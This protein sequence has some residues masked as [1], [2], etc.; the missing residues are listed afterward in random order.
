MIRRN[1]LGNRAGA[2]ATT[3]AATIATA[4]SG[5]ALSAIARAETPTLESLGHE[6]A[7]GAFTRNVFPLLKDKCTKCHDGHGDGHGSDSVDAPKLVMPED[8]SLTYSTIRRYIANWADLAHSKLVIRGTSKDMADGALA[9]EQFVNALQKWWDEGE[10]TAFFEG[11]KV[12]SSRKLPTSGEISLN[13]DLAEV[14]PQMKGAR[15]EIDV[16]KKAGAY[17]LRNP[18][19]EA[20]TPV[21]VHGIHIVMNGAWNTAANGYVNINAVVSENRKILSHDEVPLLEMKPGADELTFAFEKI[22]SSSKTLTDQKQRQRDTNPPRQAQTEREGPRP[23]CG[24]ICWKIRALH[25]DLRSRRVR[26]GESIECRGS[27]Q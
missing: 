19:I 24:I 14:D 18:K 4:I 7:V 21:E 23:F 20:E 27:R 9:S 12:L 1:R 8:P 25:P 5:L 15:F 3:I 26:H 13:W 6:K 22:A 16:Q 17:L 10:S 2:I 11:K